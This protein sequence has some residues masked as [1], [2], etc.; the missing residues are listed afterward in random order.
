MVIKANQSER[1]GS[2]L[3]FKVQV[4]IMFGLRELENG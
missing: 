3:G 1:D 2:T 4:I